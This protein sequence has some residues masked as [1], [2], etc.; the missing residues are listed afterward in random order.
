MIYHTKLIVSEIRL[1]DVFLGCNIS[2]SFS[3]KSNI[4]SK[5]FFN[6]FFVH[7]I[8]ISS[9]YL[10]NLTFKLCFKY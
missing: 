5:V 3:E 6:L 2:F 9:I 10:M 1:K 4:F 8:I 7:N